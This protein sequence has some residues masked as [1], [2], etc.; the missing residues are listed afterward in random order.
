MNRIILLFLLPLVVAVG[1][2]NDE[3]FID[4]D[5]DADRMCTIDGDGGTATFTIATKGLEHVTIDHFIDSK[6]YTYYNCAGEEIPEN[7]PFSELARINWT[8]RDFILDVFV[9]GNKI[10]IKSTENSSGQELDFTVRLTYDYATRFIYVK[11]SPGQL[12]ELKR[13]EYTGDFEIE[14]NYQTRI[15]ARERYINNSGLA[16]HVTLQP[17][18]GLRSSC[19]VTPAQSW[20]RYLEVCMPLPEPSGSGWALGRPMDV[21]FNNT[22]YFTPK[23]QDTKVTVEIPPH[24]DVTLICSVAFTRVM[25][26]G[27]IEFTKPVSGRENSSEFTCVRIEAADYE[28]I[29]EDATE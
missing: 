7:S 23:S 11:I 10:E 26:R 4:R 12:P 27:V 15:V 20:A 22:M 2:C 21:E 13:L 5:L 18:Y 3:V 16:Q 9:Y 25:A 1:G 24:S 8:G 29:L 14:E 17:Y 28:I 19:T 6:G